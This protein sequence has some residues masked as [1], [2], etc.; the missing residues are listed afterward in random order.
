MN[1][2][3]NILKE[4]LKL[5]FENPNIVKVFYAGYND[6]IWLDRDLNIKI[7][8]YFDIQIAQSFYND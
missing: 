8:N 2:E 4:Q 7:I 1:I 6:V 5:I 3:K